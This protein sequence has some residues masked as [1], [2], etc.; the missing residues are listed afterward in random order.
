M[1][2][3][4][5]DNVGAVGIVKDIPP[6]LLPPE[7]WTSGLNIRFDEQEFC[8]KFTGSQ[9][10][11]NITVSSVTA[12][13][14]IA[15][16]P[17]YV[18][19]VQT[20]ENYFWMYCGKEHIYAAGPASNHNKLTRTAGGSDVTYS[21]TPTIRWVGGV[22]AG[23]PILTNAV[24]CPQVWSPVQLNTVC[25]DM[26]WDQS[27]SGGG[28]TS[29]T[30]RTAGSVTCE[31]MRTFREF[32]IAMRTV[33]A[34]VSYPRRMRWSHPAVAGN[35]PATWDEGR[36]DYDAGYFDF[37]ETGDYVVDCKPMRDVLMLYKEQ[38]TWVVQYIGGAYVMAR[39]Q[40]FQSVGAIAHSCVAE[41]KGNHAVFGPSDIILHDGQTAQSLITKKWRPTLFNS[42]DEDYKTNC[43]TVTN[44]PSQEIWFCYPEAGVTY[45]PWCTHAIVWNWRHNT[46]S[47][48]E[49]QRAAHID[50]GLID[51]PG[52]P[53]IT[54]DH[55]SLTDW[56]N[57][58]RIWGERNFFIGERNLLQALPTDLSDTAGFTPKLLKLDHTQAFDGAAMTCTLERTGITLV[59]QDRLGNP[60]T[61][62]YHF[63][64]LKQVRP[65]ILGNPGVTV[66]VYVGGQ[67]D[68]NQAVTWRGPY[69]YTIGTTRYINCDV[70]A[71]F[72]AIKFETTGTDNWQ[73]VGYEV[74]IDPAGLY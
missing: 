21:S 46:I 49:I 26:Q 4:R 48:R 37:D 19:P 11:Y 54:W 53:V 18:M 70:M 14:D 69:T 8:K 23:L 3:V 9:E 41:F 65:R 74:T 51:F 39:R 67:N 42:I 7:A 1:A 25:S 29:W 27:A 31:V 71:R 32:G 17:W 15:I 36:V 5:I 35:Q 47:Q 50:Q 52:D 60:K 34:S 13:Q 55:P 38:H 45:P 28:P 20:G 68:T 72:L 43:F 62:P 10:V 58:V 57:T 22:L 44:Y 2:R 16:S 59:G 64:H 66:N 12:T 33:E 40:L 61:D 56:Q 30:T 63:K 6:E 73:L 24:D